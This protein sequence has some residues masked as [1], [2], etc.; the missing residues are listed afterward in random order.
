MRD[1]PADFIGLWY[2]NQI[3]SREDFS[4]FYLWEDEKFCIDNLG[5]S[6]ISEFTR[7]GEGIIFTKEYDDGDCSKRSPINYRGRYLD[8]N[9]YYQGRWMISKAEKDA[10][11]LFEKEGGF[12]LTELGI[13]Q[14]VMEKQLLV[15]E[16]A[17]LTN[18]I[19]ETRE[20]HPSLALHQINFPELI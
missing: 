12:I 2:E 17:L 6:R 9:L 13:G 5:S 4:L 16:N 14:Y 3:K 18:K 1:I 15:L 10:R 11:F 8:G 7:N 19:K 20:Q